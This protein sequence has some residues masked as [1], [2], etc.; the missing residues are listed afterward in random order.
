[1]NETVFMLPA[2]SPMHPI[3]TDAETYTAHT[4]TVAR[5]RCRFSYEQ[6]KL[7]RLPRVDDCL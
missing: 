2:E 1:M 7:S 4:Q 5:S 6:R 3:Y